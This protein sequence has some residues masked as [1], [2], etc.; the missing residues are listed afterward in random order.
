MSYSRRGKLINSPLRFIVEECSSREKMNKTTRI[1]LI[2]ISLLVLSL[3][4]WG[5]V[6]AVIVDFDGEVLI[7]RNGV[8]LE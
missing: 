7:S 2:M 5:G 6:S 1:L 4:V 8:F 3:P